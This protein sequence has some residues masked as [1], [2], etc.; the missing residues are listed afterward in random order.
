MA[1]STRESG[2][3]HARICADCDDLLVAEQFLVGGTRLVVAELAAEEAP[4][5]IEATLLEVF[6]NHAAAVSSSPV[7]PLPAL[8]DRRSFWKPASIAASI[9]IFISSLVFVWSYS[10]SVNDSSEQLSGLSLPVELPEPM[11]VAI[12]QDQLPM[13]TIT[14]SRPAASS[15]QRLAKR[16]LNRTEVVTEFYPLTEGEDIDAGEVTQ[17]VRVELPVSALSAAGIPVSPDMST[18]TVKAEVALGYDGLARAVRF[19]RER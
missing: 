1:A 17:V 2:L 7:I 11:A 15:S 14:N 13:N 8:A 3:A 6:R 4:A 10:H 12:K 9:L 5:R 18:M 16:R 19:V